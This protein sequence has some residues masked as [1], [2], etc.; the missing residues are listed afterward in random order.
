ML[1]FKFA[2]IHRLNSLMRFIEPFA[3]AQIHESWI[4]YYGHV[5]I[6]FECTVVFE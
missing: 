2:E 5:W 4:P 3:D 6:R 1:E